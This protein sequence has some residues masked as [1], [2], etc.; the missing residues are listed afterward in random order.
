MLIVRCSAFAFHENN[1]GKG[2]MYKTEYHINILS[3][4]ADQ[5]LVL[6]LIHINLTFKGLEGGRGR[7]SL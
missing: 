4:L 5:N 7:G 3:L 2:K 6:S 1:G